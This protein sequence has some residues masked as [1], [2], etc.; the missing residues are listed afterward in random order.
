MGRSGR[1]RK[2]SRAEEEGAQ[3]ALREA[4]S[5]SESSAA[6][7]RLAARDLQIFGPLAWQV[8]TPLR[9][10]RATVK[11]P[12][13]ALEEVMRRRGRVKAER[14]D[15]TAEGRQEASTNSGVD[16]AWDALE[17]MHADGKTT[18]K[19]A[20]KILIGLDCVL[21]RAM[22]GDRYT[23]SRMLMKTVGDG[24]AHLDPTR[25][26]RGIAL[27]ER[28]IEMQPEAGGSESLHPGQSCP[29]CRGCG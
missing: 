12:V 4:Q 9:G 13:N 10:G 8:P 16:E 17:Q 20:S 11:T 2:E 1:G 6:E 22:G 19:C 26:Y 25:A 24:Q 28:F 27:V 7:Q 23:V 14:W 29:P 5:S 3:D 18:D 21:M 15:L